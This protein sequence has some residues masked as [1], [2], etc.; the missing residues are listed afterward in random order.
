MTSRFVNG[1]VYALTC[2]SFADNSLDCCGGTGDIWRG[3]TSRMATVRSTPSLAMVAVLHRA[4][5][6]PQE[7]D[8][9]PFPSE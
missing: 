4:R 8:E 2:V 9:R 3:V 1:G 6:T 7:I 5:L